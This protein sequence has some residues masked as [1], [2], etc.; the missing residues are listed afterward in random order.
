MLVNQ[1]FLLR[2][3]KIKAA[4]SMRTVMSIKIT[5]GNKFLVF[6]YLDIL[7]LLNV[8]WCTEPENDL[9]FFVVSAVFK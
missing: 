4:L 9:S 3:Q 7:M 5:L 8:F 2:N 6:F 1:L